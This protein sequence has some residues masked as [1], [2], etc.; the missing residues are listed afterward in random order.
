MTKVLTIGAATQDIIIEYHDGLDV[1]II[2]QDV[3][4]LAFKEGSK[5][6]VEKL[7]YATGGGATNS[8]V[9]FH[10]LGCNVAAFFKVGN[11]PAG[12]CIV[13]SLQHEGI[14]VHSA[15]S[16]KEQTGTSF[17][18]P[19]SKKD[20]VI[21]TYRGAN[22]TV[23][24]YDIPELLFDQLNCVYITSLTN[25]AANIL[26]HLT[27]LAQKKIT[28]TNLKVA[29]NPGISQLTKNV[30]PLK[31]ALS[32]IDV[33]IMNSQE[34]KL[35]MQSLKPRFFKSTGTGT[36]PDGPPLARG[37]IS[38]EKTTFTLHEYFKEILGYGVKRVVV[39]D[40]KHGVYVATKDHLFYHPAIP[41]EVVNSL[42]AGDAFGSC[43]VATLLQGKKIEDS[44]RSGIL[45]ASSVIMHHDAKSG[46]LTKSELKGYLNEFDTNLLKTYSRTAR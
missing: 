31:A 39:T 20:R 17:I 9:S 14:A 45:N 13:E 24:H 1:S 34:M 25:K 27:H 2:T 29:V 21:F 4:H 15:L 38:H 19:S 11:D 28:G 44:I 23:E 42:G 12:T 30:A 32:T 40:G 10:Q 3:P 16:K 18:I 46:L 26:P 22:T 33:L 37:V 7:H 5:I 6:E 43:F 35:F 41:T 36:I 8:A